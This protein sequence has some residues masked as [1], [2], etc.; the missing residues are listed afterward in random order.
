[1]DWPTG[2]L[3]KGTL[4]LARRRYVAERGPH[5]LEVVLEGLSPSDQL[6]LRGVV[7]PSSWYP[8]DLLRRFEA[9]I[10]RVLG[11]DDAEEILLDIGRATA[12]A[13]LTGNGSQ[14]SY[15]RQDPHY[16]LELSPGIYLSHFNAGARTYEKTG[17]KSAMVRTTKPFEDGEHEPCRVTIGWL[18]RA[19]EI[20]GGRNVRVSGTRCRSGCD[21]R[22][23]ELRCEWD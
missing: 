13:S 3:V 15:V 20:A 6:Q 4:I 2:P 21:G 23:C 18:T 7:L 1:M 16:V 19:I 9:Q 14:R 22:S 5:A 8:L 12:T 10:L 17:E 11:Q